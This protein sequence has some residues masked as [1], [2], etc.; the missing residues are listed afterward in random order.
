LEINQVLE[1]Q[2]KTY[3]GILD[4]NYQNGTLFWNASEG[5]NLNVW[6]LE[7][8]MHEFENYSH[9]YLA[10]SL[11]SF[12]SENKSANISEWLE[13][14]DGRLIFMLEDIG[15]AKLDSAST[16][17]TG[18][19]N[20]NQEDNNQSDD[21]EIEKINP[22]MIAIITALIMFVILLPAL[23]MFQGLR[24]FEQANTTDEQE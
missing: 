23:I 9:P 17:P 7:D 22:T 8:T 11:L 2:N 1:N 12:K 21:E 19:F 5:Y 13:N 10:T 20:F 24:K 18:N 16:Q 14:W 15:P 4:I 3:S 6:K